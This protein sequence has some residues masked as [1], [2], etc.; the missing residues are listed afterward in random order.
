MQAVKEIEREREREKKKGG[1][2]SR[3]I[4]KLAVVVAAV[5]R[6]T[7]TP[8]II[9]VIVVVVVVVVAVVAAVVVAA[10]ATAAVAAAAAAAAVCNIHVHCSLPL[11]FMLISLYITSYV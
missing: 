6:I 9:V 8:C 11:Q 5:F 3:Q 7:H 10:A 4:K 1:L 2:G